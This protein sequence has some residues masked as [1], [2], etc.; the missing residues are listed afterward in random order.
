ML[1]AGAGFAAM[2]A[3]VKLAADSVTP[4]QAAFLRSAFGVALVLPLLLFRGDRPGLARWRTH[5]ARS[6]AGIASMVLYFAAVPLLPVSTAIALN[7]TSGLFLPLLAWALLAERP[8]RRMLAGVACGFAGVLFVVAPRPDTQVLGPL[9]ALLS[10]AALA[11]A[12]L[13]IRRLGRD[14]EPVLVQV[15]AFNVLGTAMTGLLLLVTRGLDVPGAALPWG[16]A[17]AAAATIGQYGLVSALAVGPAAQVAALGF[18]SIAAAAC[19]DVA[20]FDGGPSPAIWPGLAL[21]A[22]GAWISSTP[23]RMGT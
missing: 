10:G 15:F 19:L 7:G 12:H 14:R 11:F 5:L 9:L 4:L 22:A 21:V 17:I 6:S 16:L 3:A 23:A 13:S 20:L 18:V 8:T 1:V 2:G